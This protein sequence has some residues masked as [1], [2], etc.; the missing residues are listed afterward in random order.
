MTKNSNCL[1]DI[2][3]FDLENREWSVSRTFGDNIESRRNHA[4]CVVGKYLFI[5]GGINHQFKYLNDIFV[6]DIEV[7][8]WLGMDI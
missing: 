2:R 5:Y 3:I 8:K 1:N 4:S 7:G 6:Y